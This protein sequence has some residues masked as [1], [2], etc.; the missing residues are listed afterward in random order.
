MR[1]G[2]PGGSDGKES[3]CNVGEDLGS[4]PGSGRRPGE[5]MAAHSSVPSWRIP[6]GRG[7][8]RA[9]V[10]RVGKELETTERPSAAQAVRSEGRSDCWLGKWGRRK[11]QGT[12]RLGSAPCPEPAAAGSTRSALFSARGPP[13]AGQQV[14]CL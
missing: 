5:G 1:L 14:S 12:P 10:H 8:W 6:M 13:G 7:A 4:S 9:T 2:F 3:T 11:A